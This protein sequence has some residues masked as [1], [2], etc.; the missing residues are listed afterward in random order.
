[1]RVALRLFLFA[2]AAIWAQPPRVFYFPKP[3]APTPYL[4]PMKPLT[5]LA[6]LKAKHY[7]NS[8]W[9]EL[10]ID[11][12]NS[13]AYV[14]SAAPGSKVA[15]HLFPD[16]PA[17]WVVQEG[18]IRFEIE[19]PQGWQKFE[20]RKGSY[21]FAPERHLHSLEVVGNKPAIR[22]EVTL[23]AATPVFDAPPAN[24]GNGVIE[25]I[26]VT[27]S[28]GPN[29]D[30][31]PNK[32]G[33]GDRIHV[34]IED[35]EAAHRGQSAWSEPA[36]RKNRVRGNFIYGHA[37]DNPKRGPGYR[38]H[39]HADFAEFWIVLRG[40]LQWIMEG[41]DHPLLA[42]EGDIVYAPPKRFHIPEFYGDGPACRLTSS[43]YPSANHI[44]DA[45]TDR[46][47]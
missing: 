9:S 45:A 6:D 32:S 2:A 47:Q 24:V 46:K 36:Q 30:D 43:T 12:G 8:N 15:R 4:A 21:V 38:G 44:F 29:P 28:T 7:G 11:D 19:T 41:I 22:F 34:N 27:L 25:Y 35:L 1:M 14:I 3:V 13:R 18:R 23:A 10:V 40:Q 39:M 37:R 20:A 42:S 26:P 31:V 5:R 17:W 16:S 33:K